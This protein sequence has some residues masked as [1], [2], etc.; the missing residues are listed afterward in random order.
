VRRRRPVRTQGRDDGFSLIEL[1]VTIG[2]MSVVGAIFT[3]AILLVYQTTVRTESISI[4]QA[5]LQRAF[6]RFDKEL[7]YA[8]WIAEPGRFGT[9][10]YVEF[11]AAD[12]TQCRQ[13]RF[14]TAVPPERDNDI[15]GYGLL[16]MISWTRGTPPVAGTTGQTIAS[17]LVTSDVD[18]PFERQAAGI[19]PT[20]GSGAVGS[21]FTPEFQ[22]LRI[23][24]TT[25]VGDTVAQVD[26]TFTAL[27]TSRDTTDDNG[28][29]EG[30]PT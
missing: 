26:T 28:C 12:E 3:A 24:L 9:A 1:M 25:Q 15:D 27:N 16:Q 8:S 17:Q 5:Q 10:W 7:R 20:S 4:A 13:L 29:A 2:V 23:R 14:E 30:R 11:A 19:P 21:D 22:R 6:E 18:G